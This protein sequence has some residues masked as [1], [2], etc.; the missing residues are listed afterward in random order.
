MAVASRTSG[1]FV[2]GGVRRRAVSI[3]GITERE[4]DDPAVETT[5]SG[6]VDTF[7]R[8]GGFRLCDRR[9][10]RVAVGDEARSAGSVRHRS[11][12]WIWSKPFDMN[13]ERIETRHQ[14]RRALG[15]ERLLSS[16]VLGSL[17]R[18]FPH[19]RID[20]GVHRDDAALH[21]RRD[22]ATEILV[23]RRAM[24]WCFG[25][26]GLRADTRAHGAT[27]HHRNEH[28]RKNVRIHYSLLEAGRIKARWPFISFLI[29]HDN[30]MN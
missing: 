20:R 28:R 29:D 26:V 14:N 13:F 1:R 12:R 10:E 22:V 16:L 17:E 2:G 7:T 25:R 19:P 18:F 15:N 24:N 3:V 23:G 8:C 27:Q 21:E 11:I 9:L 30:N 6:G 5:E 4:V